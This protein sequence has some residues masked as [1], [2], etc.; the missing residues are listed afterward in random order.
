MKFVIL[1][2][3][4]ITSKLLRVYLR[5]R[6]HKQ[7]SIL[8]IIHLFFPLKTILLLIPLYSLFFIS[9]HFSHLLTYDLLAFNNS[10]N[11]LYRY[12]K[13]VLHWEDL[14][15]KLKYFLE[16]KISMGNKNIDVKI[17]VRNHKEYT[18][19]YKDSLTIYYLG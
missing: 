12:Y 1:L 18:I 16:K 3:L 4:W 19:I 8:F 5:F 13:Q 15:V 10:Y 7:I 17:L 14:Y 2:N 9:F 11:L 6:Y